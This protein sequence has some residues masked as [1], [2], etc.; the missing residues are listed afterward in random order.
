MP[1]ELMFLLLL[2]SPVN[3]VFSPVL[4]WIKTYGEMH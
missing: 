4:P 2:V 3:H 1:R